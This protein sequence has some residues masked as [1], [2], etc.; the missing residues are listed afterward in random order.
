M[1]QQP[2]AKAV[3]ALQ[4]SLVDLIDL[5][6]GGKQA[7]WNMYG[8][9]FR[10]EHLHLDEVISEVRAGSDTV[11]ERLVTIG[12]EPD[13]RA[14]TVADAS[15]VAALPA[16]RLPVDKVLQQFE[17]SLQATADR[18]KVHIDALD[19]D[20]LLTQDI[21]ISIATGLEKQAWMFRAA[22]EG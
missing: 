13:G 5:S 15:K 2:S 21:L 22:A 7:H 11:A 10:S 8:S 16:G 14:G 6:L 1:A 17:Q 9:L 19:D 12:G 20:D 4:E 3:T 18:M